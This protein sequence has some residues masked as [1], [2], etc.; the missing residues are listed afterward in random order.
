M[1]IIPKKIF[2]IP[3]RNREQQKLHFSIYM[4][5]ILQDENEDEYKIF[6]I[7]QNDNQPFNRGAM[8]NI[9]FLVIKDIFPSNYKDITLVF[10]DIDTMP[11]NKNIID[12]NTKQGTVKHFYGFEFAL[13]GIVSITAGDFEKIGGFCNSWG[14]GLEDNLLNKRALE[15]NLIIDRS[16]FFHILN[17]N[18]IHL[19]DNIKKLL[20][21]QEVWRY[22]DR[23]SDS[24]YDI[25][26]L[27]Y[28][29]DKEFIHVDNFKT[30]HPPEKENYYLQT[31]RT[32]IYKDRNFDPKKRNQLN[33]LNFGVR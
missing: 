32:I 1:E 27:D 4:N 22:S 5:Y 12:Y 26:N 29:I 16:N 23:E 19:N 33:N 18:I 13:G 30:K 21:K 8:K 24:L 28:R 7:H 9:G 11:F 20:S 17:P 6:F 31:N 10:N 3:Y 14:W 2:I 25:K 15:N